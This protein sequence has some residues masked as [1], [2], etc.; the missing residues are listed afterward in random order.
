MVSKGWKIGLGIAGGII[1]LS[2]LSSSKKEEEA[3]VGGS[4]GSFFSFLRDS[5]GGTTIPT[6]EIVP[7]TDN[8]IQDYFSKLKSSDSNEEVGTFIPQKSTSQRTLSGQKGTYVRGGVP[9]N[10]LT[11]GEIANISAGSTPS[12]GRTQTGSMLFT[13]REAQE[14][15]NNNYSN[16]ITGFFSRFI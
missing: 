11:Q 3:V 15:N 8:S 9:A 16:P 12:E 1:L 7:T 5:A 10:Q 14:M 4:G 2:G 13:E 6:F